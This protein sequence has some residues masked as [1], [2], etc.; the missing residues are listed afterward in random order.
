MCLV[1][2]LGF[3]G[4]TTAMLS[5]CGSSGN[6]SNPGM[7]A[8]SALPDTSLVDPVNPP[9]GPRA[10]KTD[11][12][13]FNGEGTSTS[14]W[15]S[16]Q[17]ILKSVK[18]SYELVNSEELDEMSLDE[19]ASFGLLIFP[20]GHGNQIT[21]G[22]SASTAIRVRQA[23]RDRGVSFLGICAGAWIAVGP[24]AKSNKSASYGF[25]VASG[26]FLDEYKPGGESPTAAIVDVS[27][28]DG[29]KR[30]LVWWGGP[31]TPSWTNGVVA[32]YST[33]EPAISETWSGRGFVVVVGPHPEAPEGW[34][35]T[36]GNDP[37]GLDFDIALNLIKS[38]LTR[39][40]LKT[41]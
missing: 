1:L 8:S 23:V 36:A 4:L 27:F 14:D 29:T 31:I 6:V 41:F 10:S 22:V 26:S 11:V 37:D 17:K 13:L 19:L 33:G 35:E 18:L 5:G 9:K 2:S 38:A 3:L 20:G 15:Q 7:S 16:L 24:E 32:K 21:D 12:L 25:A 28:A 30:D 40:P 39:T 34:R